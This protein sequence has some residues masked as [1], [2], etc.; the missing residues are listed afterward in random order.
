MRCK[1]CP[2]YGIDNLGFRSCLIKRKEVEY[3]AI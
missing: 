2:A 3:Y 1:D